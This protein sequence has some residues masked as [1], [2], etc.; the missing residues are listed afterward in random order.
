MKMS[1]HIVNQRI[2]NVCDCAECGT[3]V[4][5]SPYGGFDPTGKEIDCE[6]TCC[7]CGKI[8]CDS[9]YGDWETICYGDPEDEDHGKVC[10]DCFAKIEHRLSATAPEG[11]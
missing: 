6:W 11:S 5:I 3:I 8:V 2:A 1:D 10:G 7:E 9:C 4:D